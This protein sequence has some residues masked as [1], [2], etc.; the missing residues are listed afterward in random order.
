MTHQGL[1]LR[2]IA[3]VLRRAPSSISREIR[4]NTIAVA[5]VPYDAAAAGRQA[6]QRLRQP[7]RPRKLQTHSAVFIVVTDLLR[8]GWSPQQI[9][10]RLRERYPDDPNYHV[11]HEIIYA[12]IRQRRLGAG[13]ADG[14]AQP[15][16]G[17]V[18]AANPDV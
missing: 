4:R 12:T 6:R 14:H 11:S 3:A 16:S 13:G 5:T 9:Q 15:H 18:I 8:Q 1:S 17:A 2:H 10:G 7:R